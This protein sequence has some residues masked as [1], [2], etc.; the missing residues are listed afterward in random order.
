MTCFPLNFKEE[1]ML[2]IECLFNIRT[3]I[4]LKK[5]NHIRVNNESADHLQDYVES[6]DEVSKQGIISSRL[7]PLFFSLTPFLHLLLLLSDRMN[8][9]DE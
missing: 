3:I 6:A 7:L 8:R 1:I 4:N 9:H 2:I 5:K